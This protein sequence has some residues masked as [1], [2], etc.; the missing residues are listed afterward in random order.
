MLRLFPAEGYH[1][2]N[3][4]VYPLVL[5]STTTEANSSG[6]VIPRALEQLQ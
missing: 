5:E 2:S 4:S 6:Q 3:I 1:A